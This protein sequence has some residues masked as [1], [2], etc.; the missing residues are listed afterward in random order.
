MSFWHLYFVE[1]VNIIY[2]NRE[3]LFEDFYFVKMVIKKDS[4]N[5]SRIYLAEVFTNVNMKTLETRIFSLFLYFY[6]MH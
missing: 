3:D 4:H 2:K 1:N 6:L 5:G